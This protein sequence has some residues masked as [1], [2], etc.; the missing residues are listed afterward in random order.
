LRTNLKIEIDS[1]CLWRVQ[2]KK[3]GN[4]ELLKLY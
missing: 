1:F 2:P 3:G 4:V